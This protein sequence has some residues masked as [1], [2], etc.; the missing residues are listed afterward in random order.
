LRYVELYF[1]WKVGL[2]RGTVLI[3]I[4]SLLNYKE[5]IF[6]ARKLSIRLGP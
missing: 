3:S 2:F 4:R 6:M 1:R 5:R